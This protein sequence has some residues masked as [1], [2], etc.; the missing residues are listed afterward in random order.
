MMF[1][2]KNQFISIFVSGFCLAFIGLFTLGLSGSA[3]FA[4]EQP[5]EAKVEYH[6]IYLLQN[7]V[8]KDCRVEVVNKT[9]VRLVNRAGQASVVP[10]N[11]LIG[12]DRHPIF[13]KLYIRSLHGIGLPGPVLVPAAFADGNDYVCKYCDSFNRW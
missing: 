13:R 11:Q 3:C 5:K 1:F 7:R 12:M 2:S 6:D 9:N 10:A 4:E 8:C